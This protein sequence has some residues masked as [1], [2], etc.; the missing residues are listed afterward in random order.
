MRAEMLS[1]DN[2]QDNANFYSQCRSQWTLFEMQ[3]YFKEA[4]DGNVAQCFFH[5]RNKIIVHLSGWS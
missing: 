3:P 5:V 1:A 4:F 2:V